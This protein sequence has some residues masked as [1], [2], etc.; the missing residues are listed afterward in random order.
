MKK[1]FIALCLFALTNICIAQTGQ[2]KQIEVLVNNIF[3]RSN[4]L[5]SMIVFNFQYENKYTMRV[6]AIPQTE[7]VS[8][9]GTYILSNSGT[10][11]ANLI[12]NPKYIN[13][14]SAYNRF[15]DFKIDKF[16]Y[17]NLQF[18]LR[19]FL[20]SD[21]Q[22]YISENPLLAQASNDENKNPFYILQGNVNFY[23]RKLD[24]K[25]EREDKIKQQKEK[26][27]K[28]TDLEEKL[29]GW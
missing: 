10:D 18:D 5:T 21:V 2:S 27:K 23:S 22:K 29:K 3:V 24:S 4:G 11:K 26:E 7:I 8:V 15:Q 28:K 13:K 1:T 17:S 25:S 20:E 12:L 6:I 14:S 16:I 9:S 19:K